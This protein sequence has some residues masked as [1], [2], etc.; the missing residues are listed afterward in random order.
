MTSSE[1]Q[2]SQRPK[3]VWNFE[4]DFRDGR[5]C[6][7]VRKMEVP[8]HFEPRFSLEVGGIYNDAPVRFLRA[9][10]MRP[11]DDSATYRVTHDGSALATL[12][13][14]AYEYIEE[15]LNA[16]RSWAAENEIQR[17]ER[18][19]RKRRNHESNLARRREEDRKRAHGGRG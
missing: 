17:R 6:V 16:W 5:Y 19:E 18:S 12:L 14:Q 1:L 8:A 7:T 2:P 9:L 3:A 10:V 4:R 11:D 15:Q 13:D